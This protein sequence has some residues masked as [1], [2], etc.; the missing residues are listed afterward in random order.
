MD[1]LVNQAFHFSNES[2][3]VAADGRADDVNIGIYH[4]FKLNW[5][6]KIKKSSKL[7]FLAV[8]KIFPSA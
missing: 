5:R 3:P 2:C 4:P 7:H 1:R 8:I 6:K